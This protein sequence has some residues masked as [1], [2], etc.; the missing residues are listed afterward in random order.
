VELASLEKQM[1]AE[2]NVDEPWKLVEKFATLV[3]LSGS[4]EE[5]EA[6]EYLTSRLEAL[7]IRFTVY[8]PEL[9]ISWP[10]SAQVTSLGLQEQVFPA[11]APSFSV[12][13]TVEGELV[14]VPRAHARGTEEFFA[15]GV[16]A[17]GPAV[18]GKVVV[19]DGLALPKGVRDLEEAGAA[20]QIYVNPHPEL[21]HEGIISPIWGSPGWED[22]PHRARSLVVNV[23]ATTGEVLKRLAAQEGARVR[24]ETRLDERWRKCPIVVAEVRGNQD[25]DE[26]VLVHGHLDSWHYG[27]GDNAVGNAALLELARVFHK[28]RSHLRRTLRLAWWSGHSHGRYAGS[29]W[30]AD[31][32]AL[33]LVENCVAQSNIDSVGCRWATNFDEVMWM[34][35]AAD[36]CADVIRHL[37]GQQAHGVRPLRAGDYSFNNLGL[38]AFYMLLSNIPEDVR[39]KKGFYAVGGCGGNSDAWHTERDTLEVADPEILV[40]DIRVYVA[41]LLRVLNSG[42]YPFDFR[43]TVAEIRGHIERYA[44]AAGARFDF[45]PSLEEVDRLARAVEQ[46][47]TVGR[48]LDASTDRERQKRCNRVLRELARWLVPLNYV[49]RERFWHDPALEVPPVP[50]LAA[51][52]RLAC[53]DAGDPTA[54]FIQVDLRRGQNHVVWTLRQARRAVEEFLREVEPA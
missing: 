40:R 32:F 8:E 51:A 45:T 28:F 19:T 4:R 3:R 21:I 20:A 44:Q 2:V 13:G 26:F 23:S 16:E 30:Y 25:P 18:Q 15:I 1:L 37:T 38:T 27:V 49:R 53:V 33:D 43:A 31:T 50:A 14:Y 54:N 9:Y 34:S 11:K 24:V 52:E 42:V 22:L 12:S 48:R 7:G 5:K 10:L 46:L 47:W 6:V 39:R 17:R 41:T 36:L 29:T 35:E